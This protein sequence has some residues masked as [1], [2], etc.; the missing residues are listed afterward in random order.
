MFGE[1]ELSPIHRL[2]NVTSTGM[3]LKQKNIKVKLQGI[4][5]NKRNG[6]A[7]MP[8]EVKA[9]VNKDIAADIKDWNLNF[10]IDGHQAQRNKTLPA[11][12]QTDQQSTK[13]GDPLSNVHENSLF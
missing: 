5:R 4:T 7:L 11:S 13:D 8:G 9:S 1:P 10:R 12:R 2:N 6:T 3:V